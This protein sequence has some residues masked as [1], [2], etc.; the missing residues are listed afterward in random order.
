MV[1]GKGNDMES[2][3]P[4]FTDEEMCRSLMEELENLSEE[5]WDMLNEM[6][7]G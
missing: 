5:E 1:R 6:A 3:T 7:Q 4:T 2:I